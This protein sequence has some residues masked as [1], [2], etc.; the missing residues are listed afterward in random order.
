MIFGCGS[1]YCSDCQRWFSIFSIFYRS[2]LEFCKKRQS[3]LLNVLICSTVYSYYYGITYLF[4]SVNNSTY[5]I[6]KIVLYLASGRFFKLVSVFRH[7]RII[8]WKCSSLFSGTTKLCKHIFLWHQ[9]FFPKSSGLFHWKN[10][11]N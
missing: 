7:A 3:L 6:V 11:K 4:Y 2:L 8:F 9:H 10:G 1:Y 5:L